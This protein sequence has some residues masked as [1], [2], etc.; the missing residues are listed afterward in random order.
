ML[1]ALR[2]ELT[3]A[4]Q[5]LVAW[6]EAILIRHFQPVWCSIIS[7]FGIHAPGKGRGAQMRSMWDQIHPGRSFAEKL[8][9]NP[10][11]VE[12]LQTQVTQHCQNLAT[13]LGCPVEDE[14]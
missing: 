9:P 8:S 2:L 12:S 6:G 3:S 1:L 7:G 11:T 5:L 10:V 13:R 4:L 14:G